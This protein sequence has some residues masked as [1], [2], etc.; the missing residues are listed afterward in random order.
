MHP[1]CCQNCCQIA[2]VNS[3]SIFAAASACIVG[4]TWL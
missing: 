2:T 3:A 4:V 1:R